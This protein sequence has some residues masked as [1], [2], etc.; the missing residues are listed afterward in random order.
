MSEG[1]NEVL[2]ACGPSRGFSGGGGGGGGGVCQVNGGTAV[3]GDS[4]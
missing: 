3:L 2:V 1:G 4:C